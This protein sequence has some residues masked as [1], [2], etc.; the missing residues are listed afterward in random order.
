MVCPGT[1]G[2]LGAGSLGYTLNLSGAPSR[3]TI[4]H[5]DPRSSES[6]AAANSMNQTAVDCWWDKGYSSIRR[7]K[8]LSIWP[9][10]AIA[11]ICLTLE[12]LEEKDSEG[13]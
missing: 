3:F 12:P 5:S 13:F 10:A 9:E 4:R 11:Q 8:I 6:N 2:R 7:L 1:G